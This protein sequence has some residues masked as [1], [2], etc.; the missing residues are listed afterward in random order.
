MG[1]LGLVFIAVIAMFCVRNLRWRWKTRKQKNTRGRYRGGAVLG[2][3]LQNLQAF[4]QPRAEHVLAELLKEP[5]D[6][7]DEAG[8]K[9]PTAHLLRQ[10]KRI[11]KGQKIEQLTTLLPR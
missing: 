2:N 8:P 6:E 1:Y 5:A 7:D 3:A 10:A 4:A 11:Q 9:D